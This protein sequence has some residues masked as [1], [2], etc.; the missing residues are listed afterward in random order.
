MLKTIQMKLCFSLNTHCTITPRLLMFN[1]EL[2][3]A[4]QNYPFLLLLIVMPIS[5]RYHKSRIGK[6]PVFVGMLSKL[7]IVPHQI[8]LRNKT[9]QKLFHPF[10]KAIVSCSTVC[11]LETQEAALDIANH[12]VG[13]ESLCGFT[14]KELCFGATASNPLKKIVWF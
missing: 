13:V 1:K 14:F 6:Q 12:M 7:S 3:N 4:W 10:N 11:R 2:V 8:V 5:Y 9:K